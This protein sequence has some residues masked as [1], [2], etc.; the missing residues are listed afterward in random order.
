MAHKRSCGA[1]FPAR[2]HS[3]TRV[4]K[5]KPR[6]GFGQK[7][8]CKNSVTRRANLRRFVR[9]FFFLPTSLHW[10]RLRR[11]M[12]GWFSLNVNESFTFQS[13]YVCA[14]AW[15]TLKM[16]CPTSLSS[17]LGESSEGDSRCPSRSLN[18]PS[19]GGAPLDTCKV[20]P[21]HPPT[22]SSPFTL[23]NT[24]FSPS[25]SGVKHCESDASVCSNQY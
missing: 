3:H 1:T 5:Q 19:L 15:R 24:F 10:V 16:S 2:A 7:H 22:F 4:Y 11:A 6:P 14:F 20:N 13:G 8:G 17:F 9:V 18:S 12:C 21:A 23:H 25:I